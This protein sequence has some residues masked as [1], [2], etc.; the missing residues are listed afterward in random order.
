M[1][2]KLLSPTQSPRPTTAL[3]TTS[4]PIGIALQ[5]NVNP[6]PVDAELDLILSLDLHRYPDPSYPSIRSFIAEQHDLPSPDHGFLGVGSGEV[7]DLPMRVSGSASGHE[8]ILVLY[9]A[10]AQ[11]VNDVGVFKSNL[12]LTAEGGEKGERG[13]FRL[14]V[15]EVS[16]ISL[17]CSS[18]V[19]IRLQPHMRVKTGPPISS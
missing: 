19:T 11:Q 2:I 7:I 14:R 15:D 12:E 9:G 1:R 17:Q 6:F 10:C 4:A 18:L 3:S 16:R 8:K 13:R 5:I